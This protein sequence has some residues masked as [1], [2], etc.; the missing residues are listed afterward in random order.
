M[1]GALAIR[2]PSAS[3]RAQE[4][5]SRSLMFTEYAVFCRRRPIC[6]AIDMYRLLKISSITGSTEVPIAELRVFSFVR[7]RTR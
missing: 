3:N 2:L 1:C 6:S 5:S 4:K 7:S